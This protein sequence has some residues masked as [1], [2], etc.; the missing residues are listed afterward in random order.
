M[1]FVEKS[2]PWTLAEFRHNRI[3]Q[4]PHENYFNVCW[5]HKEKRGLMETT[6][7]VSSGRNHANI[8]MIK[9]HNQMQ[10]VNKTKSYFWL[11]EIIKRFMHPPQRTVISF[12]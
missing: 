10:G 4:S 1:I 7:Y 11:L 8:L 5:Q 3:V 2:I 9:L 6:I 12:S